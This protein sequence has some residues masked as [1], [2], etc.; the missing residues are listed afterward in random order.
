M[1]AASVSAPGCVVV[2]RVA[3]KCSTGFGCLLRTPGDLSLFHHLLSK[4]CA[5]HG[6]AHIAGRCST[7]IQA[8][9]HYLGTVREALVEVLGVAGN[10]S[11]FAGGMLLRG[12]FPLQ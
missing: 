9:V 1:F 6:A 2:A 7:Q 10:P 12:T 3:P 5:L 4:G 11:P 8:L